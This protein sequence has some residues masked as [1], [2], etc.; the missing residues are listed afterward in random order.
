MYLLDMTNRKVSSSAQ[1]DSSVSLVFAHLVHVVAVSMS[2]RVHFA[3]SHC[4]VGR[5]VKSGIRVKIEACLVAKPVVPR[6]AVRLRLP[7]IIM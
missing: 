3:H 7:I 2:I 6:A 4:E 5:Q 1:K